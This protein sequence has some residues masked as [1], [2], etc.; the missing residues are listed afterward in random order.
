[1]A[2]AGRPQNSDFDAPHARESSRA[3]RSG[4]QAAVT[5]ESAMDVVA[6]RKH[7]I[8]LEGRVSAEEWRTRVDLAACYRL[9]A[10]YGWTHLI[11]NHI[12]AKIPGTPNHFLINPL[13]LWYEEITASSLVKID[14]DGNHVGESPYDVI[15]AGFVIHSAVHAARP[16]VMC[17]L[18]THSIAGMAVAAMKEGLLPLSMGAMRFFGRIGYHDFE[19]V[20]DDLGERARIV[21]ALGPHM[22][23]IM[24]NHGLL[25]CGRTIGEAFIT[26]YSLER[27]CETQLKTMAATN[28]VVIPPRE[29]C[30]NTARQIAAIHTPECREWPALFRL[31]ERLDPGFRV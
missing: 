7:A 3:G 19:G 24:R 8:S 6:E 14:L 30:E 23:L 16:E 29:V 12:S 11:Y 2:A 22:A 18:H 15:K 9:V 25:A 26:M 13:G 31:V 17:V 10:H 4:G 20:A 27:A 21:R 28:A 5:S 1:M